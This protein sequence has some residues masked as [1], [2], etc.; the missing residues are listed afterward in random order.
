MILTTSAQMNAQVEL[1]LLLNKY[2]LRTC[3]AIIIGHHKFH[4]RRRNTV[5]TLNVLV[6]YLRRQR[7]MCETGTAELCAGERA[8]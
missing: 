4:D 5:L 1:H 3:C 2:F 8:N 7:C 6:I